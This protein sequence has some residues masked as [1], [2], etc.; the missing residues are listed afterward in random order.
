MSKKNEY[1]DGD[2]DDNDNKSNNIQTI[3]STA[4]AA[5]TTKKPI[6]RRIVHR[7]WCMLLLI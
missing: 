7:N 5:F 1:N 4:A 3:T 6:K 2:D